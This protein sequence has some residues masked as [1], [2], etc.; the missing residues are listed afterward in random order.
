VK[1]RSLEAAER[2]IREKKIEDVLDGPYP[3]REEKKRAPCFWS[4]KQAK[5]KGQE[6]GPKCQEPNFL[7]AR[8]S[9][10]T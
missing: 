10:I 2:R 8:A 4:D 5:R 9:I 3:A 7:G 6:K 1:R